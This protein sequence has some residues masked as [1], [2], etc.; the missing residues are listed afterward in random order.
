[1]LLV[2]LE[3]INR[4]RVVL[5]LLGMK[6]GFHLAQEYIAEV[7]DQARLTRANKVHITERYLT[8]MTLNGQIKDRLLVEKVLAEKIYLKNSVTLT[9]QRENSKANKHAMLGRAKNGGSRY[10]QQSASDSDN[11]SLTLEQC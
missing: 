3:Y 10:K 6:Q 9:I 5:K 4:L 7:K 11:H 8:R 1:M 2:L